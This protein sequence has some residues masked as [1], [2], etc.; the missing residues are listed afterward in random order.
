MTAHVL[1]RLTDKRYIIKAT[2]QVEWEPRTSAGESPRARTIDATALKII[3]R[4]G[5]PAFRIAHTIRPNA[6][7]ADRPNRRMILPMFLYD[8]DR[9]GL[10]EIIVPYM[11]TIHWNRGNW[12]FEQGPMFKH[13]LNGIILNGVI[14]DFTGDGRAD[15]LGAGAGPLILYAA[16]A[17][18]R[19]STP[20]RRVVAPDITLENPMAVTAGDIDSDGDL[21]VWI[22]QYKQPYAEGQM[23]TPYF[24]ANDGYPAY[25]FQNDGNGQFTDITATA[26]LAKKR[27]R[28]T[29]GG[30]LVD[31]DDDLDLDLVV[32]SDFS[33]LDIYRNDGRKKF[34]DVTDV[35]V[36]HRHSFGMSLTFADYNRDGKLDIFMTGMGSTTA[37]RLDQLKLGREEFPFHQKMRIEMGY[38][39]RMFLAEN[40]NA[41][42]DGSFER[43][44]RQAPFNDQV[45]RTGW[46]WGSTSLDFD[47]DGDRDIYVANGHMS[48]G[49]A[50]D[51]CTHFWRQDIYSGCSKPDAALAALQEIL[52]KNNNSMSWNGYEHNCLLMNE[53]GGGFVNVAFLMGVAFELDSRVV[54]SDDLDGDGRTDLVVF[55][56]SIESRYAFEIHVL[57]NRLA[58]DHHWI[59]IRLDEEQNGHSPLGATVVLHSSEGE[60][61]SKILCGDSFISQH[62]P[63]VHFGLGSQTKVDA[64]EVIWSDGTR[65]K[66]V[67]PQ[68][69][70]YHRMKGWGSDIE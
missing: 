39:N 22:G 34:T 3:E 25:L 69:D 41:A 12:K 56:S 48:R 33:G 60:Q 32:C 18:G 38:G 1:N 58:T 59:G 11:N 44:F 27:F 40:K 9:D 21:D 67:D 10:S 55:E 4:R 51:Y 57:E 14:A 46:S 64:V 15:Y 28:R 35:Y 26:G 23:P 20:P 2:L 70:R 43:R 24:D 13:P 19:F 6:T 61:I 17:E 30:S 53:A 54:V 49:S 63:T 42:E 29:Y 68:I 66:L 16:D 8:L 47:N 36:D 45:A 50:K 65:R 7:N 62:A 5:E 31:L 52:P 37:R